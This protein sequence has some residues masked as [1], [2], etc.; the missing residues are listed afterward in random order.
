MS[1]GQR[2]VGEKRP[3]RGFLLGLLPLAAMVL[4][5]PAPAGAEERQAAE[6]QDDAA[7]EE[8]PKVDFHLRLRGRFLDELSD[9][10]DVGIQRLSV[11]TDT[12]VGDRFQARASYDVGETRIHDLWVQYDIGGGVRLRAGRSAPIWLSEFTDA[13]FSFQMVG[14]AV[15]AALTWTRETGVFLFADRGPYNARLHVV[16]GTG[17]KAD[18]NGWKDVLAS[19]GRTFEAGGSSWKLDAGHYEG[20]DGPDD[21]LIP[22]RQTGFHLDG[23]FGSGRFFRGAA[24]RRQQ[25]GREHFGGFARVRKRLPQGLWGAVEFGSESNRGGPE[26]PG[27]ASYVLIGTR[28]ELPWTLTHLAA[29]YRR[30]FGVVT[31]NEVLV[32]FQW[33]LD[34]K[35]PRRN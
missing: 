14:A 28:Y 3:S 4:V 33:I 31:D 5:L 9:L 8:E 29:D 22:K 34:F 15:G 1:V 6:A 35:N 2:S 10:G 13:P 16:N 12:R 23:D 21:G 24:F 19:V 30:R 32:V 18:D 11:W 25:D 26:N 20:R 27:N 7:G 17:W